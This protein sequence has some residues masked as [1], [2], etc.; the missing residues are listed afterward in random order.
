VEAYNGLSSV[1][2]AAEVL[3]TATVPNLSLRHNTIALVPTLLG[4]REQLV[5]PSLLGV[6]VVLA[7]EDATGALFLEGNNVEAPNR[8]SIAVASIWGANTIVTGNLFGQVQTGDTDGTPCAVFIAD[9]PSRSALMGNIIHTRWVNIPARAVT[10]A[11]DTWNFM[12][13]IG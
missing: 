1:G 6:S 8:A 5:T 11:T 10:A 3:G 7:R 12:N 4:T 13:T 2:L 9:G